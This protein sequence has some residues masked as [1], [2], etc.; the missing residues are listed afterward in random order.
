MS[1][2]S[3]EGGTIEGETSQIVLY[4]ESTTTV[5]AIADTDFKFVKWSDDVTSAQRCDTVTN[6][7]EITAQFERTGKT[8]I[9]NYNNATENNNDQSIYLDYKNFQQA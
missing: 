5:T 1:Y 3:S 9:Y 4:G 7:T 8:F 2:L 6:N